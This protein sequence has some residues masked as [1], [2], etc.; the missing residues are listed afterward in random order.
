M[1][2]AA[3]G[4][5]AVAGDVKDRALRFVSVVRLEL[6]ASAVRTLIATYVLSPVPVHASGVSGC[7]RGV[8]R[9]VGS[10]VHGL[11]GGATTIM[12]RQLRGTNRITLR[13]RKI[14]GFLGREIPGF[15]SRHLC[16]LCVVFCVC[17]CGWVWCGVY[18][19]LTMWKVG[20]QRGSRREAPAKK[21]PPGEEGTDIRGNLSDQ[22]ACDIPAVIPHSYVRIQTPF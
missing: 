5:A 9:A 19:R 20:L 6:E 2:G 12:F 17:M 8:Q 18:G 11:A 14:D 15:W 3:W 10:G 16:W 21:W 4:I 1:V 22:P 13:R 7:R